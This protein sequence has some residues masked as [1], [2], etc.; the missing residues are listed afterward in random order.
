VIVY[1]ESNFVLELARQ[2]EEAAQAE[3]L[4]RLSEMGQ[5]ALVY[6][7]M[8]LIEP[9]STLRHYGL[10]RK[11]LVDLLQREFR[12]LGRLQPHKSLVALL[13]PLGQTL[14]SV[15]RGEMDALESALERLLNIG[16]A[17]PLTGPIF[18]GARQASRSFGLSLPDA[19][20]YASVLADL[21]F[22][23][24][25]EESC[26]VSRNPKDFDDPAITTALQRFN[27]RYIARFADGLSFV[28]SRFPPSP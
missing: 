5:C 12:E 15:E 19:I 24:G 11:R 8:A 7:A 14:L 13:Q 27:C 4:L 9:V 10:E 1:V 3:E 20:V 28:K 16:R 21:E 22:R 26:F 2:Q 6:P 25:A 18:A 23:A 17:V